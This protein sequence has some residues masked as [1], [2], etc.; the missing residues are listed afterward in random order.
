M[1]QLHYRIIEHSDS[2]L[3]YSFLVEIQLEFLLSDQVCM[4]IYRYLTWR[5]SIENND[6][7]ESKLEYYFYLSETE[8]IFGKRGS[9]HSFLREKK[10]R[11]HTAA[12]FNQIFKTGIKANKNDKTYFRW[13]RMEPNKFSLKFLIIVFSHAH[14]RYQTRKFTRR[15]AEEE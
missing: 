14:A 3:L 9:P 2:P 12:L 8:M 7:N 6:N 5:K 10:T 13:R 11:A 1:Q 4:Y 15:T